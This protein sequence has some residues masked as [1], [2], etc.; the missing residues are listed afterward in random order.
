M[1]EAPA[2]YL[3]SNDS[4]AVAEAKGGDGDGDDN[5]DDD[6]YYNVFKS[7]NQL[8]CFCSAFYYL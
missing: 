6:D 8:Q 4:C 2:G 1:E 7:S 5:D 3:D